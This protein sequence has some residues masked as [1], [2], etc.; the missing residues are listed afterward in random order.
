MEMKK[1]L[2]LVWFDTTSTIR[3]NLIRFATGTKYT[4]VSL[5]VVNK[6][7]RWVLASDTTHNAKWIS[8]GKFFEHY[9]PQEIQYI[10][11]T[12]SSWVSVYPLMP[13]RIS[14]VP[15]ALWYFVT[16]YLYPMWTPKACTSLTNE[17]LHTLGITTKNNIDLKRMYEEFKHN[18]NNH[19]LRKSKSRKNSRCAISCQGIF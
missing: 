10:G 13:Y 18:E 6:G 1:D 5:M 3:G 12:S 7:E 16:R 8:A 2:Y 9:D 4:H 11:E 14:S 17:V 19:N 15:V